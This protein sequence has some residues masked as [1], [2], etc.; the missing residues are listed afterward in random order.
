[1]SWGLARVEVQA[2]LWGFPG[3]FAEAVSRDAVAI[4]EVSDNFIPTAGIGL[5]YRPRRDVEL[6]AVFNLH[7]PIRGSGDGTFLLG[8][9]VGIDDM[10]LLI[11]PSAPE[12]ARC[13][14]GELGTF[15]R[16]NACVAF[17]LPMNAAI[18]ARYIFH[19]D[20]GNVRGDIE[21]DVGWENWGKRCDD[22]GFEAGCTS[23][24]QL[25][26]VVDA[27]GYLPD[28]NGTPQ[29]AI[30]AKPVIIEHRFVDTYSA[31]LGGSY[32][33]WRAHDVN[34]MTVR[35]GIGLDTRAAED[36]WLRADIDGA[37]RFMTAIGASYRAARYEVSLGGGLILPTST[38]NE[39]SCNPMPSPT[40]ARPGCGPSGEQ[41]P[42]EDRR[43]P[44]PIDPLVVTAQQAESPVSQGRFEA[45]YTMFMLGVT[46]WF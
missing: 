28:Q 41:Q 33:V 13:Q 1:V 43:G 3:N 27:A 42:I 5:L 31:R 18:G 25:R 32:V 2:A 20:R 16:L 26:L 22:I 24:G 21:L 10:P 29:I 40:N 15:E 7:A 44:D 39:G 30:D 8:P 36:G 45:R 38:T 17:Q 4:G 37:G 9:K 46:T 19:D 12:A 35:G 6:G 23:A 34:R 14:P 11:G